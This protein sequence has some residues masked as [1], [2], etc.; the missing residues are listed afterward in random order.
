MLFNSSNYVSKDSKQSYL[1]TSYLKC[2]FFQNLSRIYTIFF[3]IKIFFDV[4]GCMPDFDTGED[5]NLF[6]QHRFFIL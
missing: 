6:L 1:S 3:S 2:S 5:P 4:M